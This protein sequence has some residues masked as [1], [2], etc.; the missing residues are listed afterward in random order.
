MKQQEELARLKKK[1]DP[2]E[3]CYSCSKIP[4]GRNNIDYGLIEKGQEYDIYIY[5]RPV[6]ENQCKS[7]CS[8]L[9]TYYIF[10]KAC[11]TSLFK[12]QL[13]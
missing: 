5:V 13:K 10:N 3:R 1:A 4:G 8:S 9:C 7:L 2:P 12:K 6:V 11:F